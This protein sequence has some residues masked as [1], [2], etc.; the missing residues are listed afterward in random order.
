M[1][2]RVIILRANARNGP[3]GPPRS[4]KKTPL[5]KMVMDPIG[6]IRPNLEFSLILIQLEDEDVCIYA[7]FLTE[8]MCFFYR[9]DRL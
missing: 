1:K 7:Y 4:M 3:I 5:P 8:N 9:L 2:G 6:P